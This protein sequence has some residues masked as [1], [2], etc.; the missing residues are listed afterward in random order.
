MKALNSRYGPEAVL[1]RVTLPLGHVRLAH[2]VNIDTCN[3]KD[4]T[5]PMISVRR[6]VWDPGNVSHIG[7]RGVTPNEVEE[8]CHGDHVVR[9]GYEGRIILIGLTKGG[10]A[11]AIVLEPD[12]DEPGAFYPVTGRPASRAERRRYLDAK[13]GEKT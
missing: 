12:L 6:L 9:Q 13:G 7:R 3:A 4:Y 5:C 11:L 1:R 8:V 10:R 2:Q